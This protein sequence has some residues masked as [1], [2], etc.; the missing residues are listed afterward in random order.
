MSIFHRAM[1]RLADFIWTG[2][3]VNLRFTA[4]YRTACYTVPLINKLLAEGE[5]GDTYRT[6][7]VPWHEAERP[8][9]A[10]YQGDTSRCR[11]DGPWQEAGRDWVPLGGLILSPGV[12]AHLD[13]FEAQALHEKVQQAIEAVIRAWVGD[14]DL[15]SLPPV[16]EHFDRCRADRKAKAMIAAWASGNTASAT[17][18]ADNCCSGEL[19]D[20]PCDACRK[21]PEH[22]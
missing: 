20:A 16:P 13:P 7:L 4:E 3:K 19:T 9:L 14:H 17:D 2:R 18:K 10:F 22:D 1:D 11:I 8:P 21:G 5:D 12:T 6:A 15:T